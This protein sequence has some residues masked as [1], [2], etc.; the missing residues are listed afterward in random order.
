[1]DKRQAPPQQLPQKDASRRFLVGFVGRVVSI[2]DVKTF[3]RAIKIA[4]QMIPDLMSYIIGPTEEEPA[5]F[6]ECCRLIELLDL[7]MV[8]HFTGSV[9]V[10][11]Y[12]SKLDVLVLTSLS[13]G[14]PLVILEG[15]CAGLPVIT[16][17]VGA[18]REMPSSSSRQAPT[19]GVITG[20]PAQF[21]SRMT[22]G[23]P[24]LR[25]VNTSTSSLL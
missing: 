24:S 3:I 23:C 2:K 16:T 10:Q 18:C 22:S 11:T 19:S 13:E 4:Q 6:Q 9:D 20:S 17:D 21:P 8:V 12:Y 14:Q 25:L 1:M 7:E 5:Y 15:N